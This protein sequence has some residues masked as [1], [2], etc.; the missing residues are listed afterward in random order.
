LA[1]G[2]D[3]LI[4]LLAQDEDNT[5]SAASGAEERY[6]DYPSY[7]DFLQA[8]GNF[9]D[10]VPRTETEAMSLSLSHYRTAYREGRAIPAG[11]PQIQL[12]YMIGELARRVDD[13]DVAQEFLN[14][15][16]RTGRDW[17]HKLNSDPT[18][19][20]LARRIVELAV[21]QLHSVRDSLNA[22]G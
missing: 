10:G 6:G 3:D 16:I 9:W 12:A 15:A 4:E 21:E 7:F 22:K 1:A 18:K 14:L 8:L 13:Y 20:A 5:A 2:T 17:I 11:N 19:T